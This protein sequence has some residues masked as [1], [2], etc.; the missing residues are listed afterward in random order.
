MVT[1]TAW[2]RVL[3]LLLALL[4]GLLLPASAGAQ[5]Y[6]L[7]G[8]AR[9]GQR[10]FVEKGCGS[11]HAIRGMGPTVAPDLGRIPARHFTMTQMAGIMWNH[12]PAMQQTAREKGIAWKAFK[13][14]E[15]RDLIAFLY[16]ASLLDE[17]GDPR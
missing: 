13:G 5:Q 7:W 8:D 6:V 1:I 14:S 9:K 4:A 2:T 17:P 16:A 10:V 15:M 11:C 3:G 12:A